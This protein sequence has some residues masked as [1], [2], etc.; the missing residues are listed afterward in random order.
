MNT[1]DTRKKL[2][3]I[4]VKIAKERR[5]KIINDD[6]SASIEKNNQQEFQDALNSN[7]LQ[8]WIKQLTQAL[9]K[10][11]DSTNK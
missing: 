1:T 7:N 8:K 10:F 11:M 5:Q 3:E 2:Q 4:P 9:N 6:R